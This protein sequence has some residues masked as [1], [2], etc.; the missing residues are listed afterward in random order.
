MP[1]VE[2]TPDKTSVGPQ[3]ESKAQACSSRKVVRMKPACNFVVVRNC[4]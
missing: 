1:N 2:T 4:S 3:P